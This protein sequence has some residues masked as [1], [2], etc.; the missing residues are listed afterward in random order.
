MMVA[1]SDRRLVGTAAL[2]WKDLGCTWR[3]DIATE[4][5]MPFLNSALQIQEHQVKL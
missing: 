3:S 2:Y 4:N 5:F 1:V